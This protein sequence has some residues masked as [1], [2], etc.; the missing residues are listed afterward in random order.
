MKYLASSIVHMMGPQNS[1]GPHDP[2]HAHLW[3][4]C[5][6]EANTWC[7]LPLNKIWRL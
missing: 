7:S 1:K 3:V 4:V 5:R 2:D 6:P